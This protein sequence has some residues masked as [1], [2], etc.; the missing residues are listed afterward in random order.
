MASAACQDANLLA[1]LRLSSTES[2]DECLTLGNIRFDPVHETLE[3]YLGP[4]SHA[5]SFLASDSA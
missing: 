3:S 5:W 4:A 2:I 1:A